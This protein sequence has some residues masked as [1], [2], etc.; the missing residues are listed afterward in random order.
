MARQILQGDFDAFQ[1]SSIP[2]DKGANHCG[3]RGAGCAEKF[4]EFWCCHISLEWAPGATV[5][6]PV[7]HIQRCSMPG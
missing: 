1:S 5:A 2:Q 4:R 6:R 3:N 7:R